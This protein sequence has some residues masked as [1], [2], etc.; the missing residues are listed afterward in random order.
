M[1]QIL[2]V[3]RTNVGKSALFNRI[4]GQELSMV[5][6][7]PGI[8]RD[9]I[10]TTADFA[11]KKFK[12]IDSG[13][14]EHSGEFSD[15]IREIVINKV[16]ACSIAILVCDLKVGVTFGDIEIAKI[17][18]QSKMPVVVAVNKCD[19]QAKDLEI[20][21][22][23]KL[24]L[25]EPMP[26]S[27]I[28]GRGIGNLL[29]KALETI[30]ALRQ[31]F[32]VQEKPQ[33]KIALIGKPNAGKSSLMN[34]ILNK[35]RTMVSDVA[36]TTREAISDFFFYKDKFIQV[37]DTAG[38]RRSAS[39]DTEVEQL[40]VKSSMEA[41]RTSDV[42]ILLIDATE[43]RLSA[44]ELKLLNYA[45]AR[46]KALVIALNKSDLVSKEEL[47]KIENAF[48]Y[49]YENLWR[50]FP[51]VKVSAL[52]GKNVD[53]LITRV[54]EVCK[55]CKQEFNSQ[56][57]FEIVSSTLAKSPIFKQQTSLQVLSIKPIEGA[58][59]PAFDIKVNRP[60][61]FGDSE[62]RCIENIL[63]N[64]FNLRGCPIKFNIVNKQPGLYKYA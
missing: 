14:L 22:F 40:M 52:T 62:L 44:Q 10:E 32:E 27:A 19:D 38:V 31:S 7:Q 34:N 63:R 41:I 59:I 42:I 56:Q 12:L 15:Q 29:T 51:I 24:G 25:G 6:D 35:E 20:F 64:N 53:K 30:D 17:L 9:W 49:E 11:G 4:A 55:N 48:E 18:K 61:L 13:G 57:L 39:V 21:Q 37:T 54:E 45:C 28:H 50:N 23:Q 26:I 16:K 36:G 33:F 46:K 60:E 8:T 1:E 5:Y 47:E 2:I 43:G 58:R 3:G